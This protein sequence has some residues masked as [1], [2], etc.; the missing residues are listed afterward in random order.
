M[1]V[2]PYILFGTLDPGP[3]VDLDVSLGAIGSPALLGYDLRTAIGPITAAPGG[4]GTPLGKV[5]HTNLGALTFAQD[6]QPTT[7]GTFQATV[8]TPE[9]S[10]F[11]LLFTG[12]VMLIGVRA[13]RTRSR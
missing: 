12:G 7:V 11:V 6:I 13:R 3:V 1:P 2:V 9:P 10:S 8:T 5:T 4:V